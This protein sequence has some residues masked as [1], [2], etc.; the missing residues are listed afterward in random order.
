[1]VQ[2]SGGDG[3][4]PG[5]TLIPWSNGRPLVWDFTCPDTLAASHLPKTTDLAGAKASV[6][7]SR[8]MVK[9]TD[10]L[11]SHNFAPMA[12]ETLGPYGNGASELIGSLGGTWLS[13]P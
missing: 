1:M 11:S 4:R 9:Y 8:K 12:I 13:R 7:E 5:S 10:F 3:K 2:G 6:A